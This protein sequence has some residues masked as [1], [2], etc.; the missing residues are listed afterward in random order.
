MYNP[1]YEKDTS[2]KDKL[3]ILIF[4]FDCAAAAY[5]GKAAGVNRGFFSHKD[6]SLLKK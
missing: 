4:W 5:R 1:C 2:S 6:F 3:Y